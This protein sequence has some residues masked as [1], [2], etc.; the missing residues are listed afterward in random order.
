MNEFTLIS[1]RHGIIED[2]GQQYASLKVL[3]TGLEKKDGYVGLA[4]GKMK[5]KDSV[6][7]QKIIDSVKVLPCSIKLQ[8]EIDFAAGEK[9]T[10]IV[11]GFQL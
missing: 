8:L 6:L 5:I 10:P 11:V 9:M 7:A 3:Q 4:I 2:N 1:V